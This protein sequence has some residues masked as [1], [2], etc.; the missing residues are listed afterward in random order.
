MNIK[1]MK[2]MIYILSMFILLSA[3]FH[4]TV[5]AKSKKPPECSKQHSIYVNGESPFATSNILYIDHFT[6]KT[7]IVSVKSNNKLISGTPDKLQ[8]QPVVLLQVSPKAKNNT[9]ALVTIQIKEGKMLYVLKS[10]VTVKTRLPFKTIMIGGKNILSKLK[11]GDDSA[12]FPFEAGATSWIKSGKKKKIQIKA[13]ANIRIA[14]IA[15]VHD[16]VSYDIQNGSRFNIQK[17]DK[18][19]VRFY[20]LPPNVCK[21]AFLCMN[22]LEGYTCIGVK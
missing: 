8:G 22:M 12:I 15:C 11:Y 14:Q 6:D 9:H 17:G 18:I 3:C 4:E 19:Y 16:D 2:N 7:E 5:W 21:N 20:Y 10:Q 13:D 1:S